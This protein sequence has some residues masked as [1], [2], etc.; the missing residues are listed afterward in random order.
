MEKVVV[1]M[2]TYNGSEFLVEQLESL[3]AQEGV[4]VDIIVRDDGSLDGTKNILTDWQ[5]R[6]LLKWYTGE[7]MGP[8]ASF[9]DLLYNSPEADYYAFCDQDDVW[10]PDKLCR[11]IKQ[12][13]ERNDF[14]SLYFSAQTLIDIDKNIIGYNN[15]QR[16]FTFGESL[17]R[18]PAAGCTMVLNKGLRDLMIRERPSYVYMHD[19]WVYMVCLAVGGS[20][21]YDSRPSMF[22]RQHPNNVLGYRRGFFQKL[23]RRFRMFIQGKDSPRL[24]T[25]CQL[26]E[27][28][29]KDITVRNLYVLNCIKEYRKSIRN[30]FRLLHCNEIKTTSIYAKIALF[31]A[32]L[33]NRY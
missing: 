33:S 9:M 17:L 22:Y 10:F 11:A 19:M 25:C 28:Y 13:R 14:L 26:L 31:I 5:S 18:N 8:A 29:S 27:C 32:V 30:K 2:S 6:G 24:K 12:L 20:V 23:Y 1:L 3:C 21:V 7:N 15:P 16:L 4:F